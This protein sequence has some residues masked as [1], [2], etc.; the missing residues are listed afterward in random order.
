MPQ[1]LAGNQAVTLTGIDE[2]SKIWLV[3]HVVAQTVDNCCNRQWHVNL[4]PT[5]NQQLYIEEALGIE[6]TH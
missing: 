2:V 1:L 3:S 5:T 6:G 4:A